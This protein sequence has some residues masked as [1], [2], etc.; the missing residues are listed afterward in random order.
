MKIVKSLWEE[1]LEIMEENIKNFSIDSLESAVKLTKIKEVEESL[2]IEFPKELKVI[3]LCNN[4]T[5]GLGAILGFELI[6]IEDMLI[7][8]KL[9]KKML[10]QTNSN[11]IEFKSFSKGKVNEVA[12]DEKWIP[13]AYNNIHTYLAIDLNPDENGHTG[14]IINI[15]DA[16]NNSVKY[17]LAKSLEEL[18]RDTIMIYEYNGLAIEEE[19]QISEDRNEDTLELVRFLDNHLFNIKA[20]YKATEN[21]Y[22]DENEGYNTREYDDYQ[23]EDGYDSYHEEDDYSGY[24]E[25]DSDDEY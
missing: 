22:A 25:Y 23:D 8:Y 19:I 5:L 10:K 18:L 15:G 21:M 7:E 11:N 24:S 1:I 20:S 13:F 14:Q 12:F 17:V 9:N 16:K 6:S 2:G 3:Y 4:G